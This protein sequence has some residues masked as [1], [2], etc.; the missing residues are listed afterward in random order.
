MKL[1]F[2]FFGALFFL[3]ISGLRAQSAIDYSGHYGEYINE[4]G[5]QYDR[6]FDLVLN[7]GKYSGV[8]FRMAVDGTE[9]NSAP[10]ENL[11]VD[12]KTG[13]ISFSVEQEPVS[14][15][16]TDDGNGNFLLRLTMEKDEL[17]LTRRGDAQR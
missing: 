2:L 12:S 16:F 4:E 13:N 17:N 15:K 8:A 6:G 14:G 5:K 3:A 9:Y 7:N 1:R 11:K 10:L